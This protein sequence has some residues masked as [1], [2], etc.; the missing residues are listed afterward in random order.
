MP[1]DDSGDLTALTISIAHVM[2][3]G[4]VVH[5]AGARRAQA[6]ELEGAAQLCE[7][8]RRGLLQ[9]QGWVVLGEWY[10]SAYTQG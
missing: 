10:A 9:L 1:V 6:S 4:V 7:L 5:L 3:E 2:Q 8:L